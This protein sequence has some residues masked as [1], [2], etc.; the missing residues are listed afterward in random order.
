M[1][2]QIFTSLTPEQQN[3]A[4]A[5]GYFDGVHRG[6][7]RVLQGAA[8]QRE[9]GLLPVCFTFA[10][11][12][13][14]VIT[15]EKIPALM[16]REDKLN[17]LETLG[18]E[19]VFL[20]DFRAVMSLSA[21]DFFKTVL[22]DTLRAKA[23]F[24]GF[25]YHFGKN[26]EGDADTLRRLC[27][28]FGVALT[29]IPPETE[30]GEVVCSTLIKRLITEGDVSRANRLLCGRFGV[31]ETIRHGVRLGRKL[32]APTINQPLTQGLIVPKYGVYASAVTL[33]N[34]ERY[35]G[36]TNIGVKPTVGGSMPLWETWMPQYRGGNLYG[37]RADVRLLDFIRPE[38]KFDSLEALKDEILRNSHTAQIIY[39]QADSAAL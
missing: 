37:T 36:V 26:A 35:G 12:P 34:G 3:T 22:V 16:T 15:G 28:E 21:R 23:L 9:N 11:S 32:G 6:H 30:D 33:E 8:G 7:R 20:A 5:L 31:R 1:T 39:Q 18:I 27:D 2:M 4:V 13:K 14:E 10:Q 29:V 17:A 19:H 25:N 38:R 24:C